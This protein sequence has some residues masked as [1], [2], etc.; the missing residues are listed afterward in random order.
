MVRERLSTPIGRPAGRPRVPGMPHARPA[1]VLVA[2]CARGRRG[3]EPI[4]LMI[5][6][7]A[8][9]RMHAGEISFPGGKPDPSDAD[10]LDTALRE[11]R[12]EVNLDVGRGQVV[13]QLDAVGTAGTGFAILPF[14][15]VVAGGGPE[16]GAGARGGLRAAAGEVDEIIEFPLGPLLATMSADDDPMHR[17]AHEMLAF[18]LGGRTVWGASA[19]ILGQVARR[20]GVAPPGLGAPPVQ[21]APG[22]GG[23]PCPRPGAGRAGQTL[24]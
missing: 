24:V 5:R 7:R 6:K 22:A 3:G 12:E 21:R 14:A 1:A 8:G 18:S 10:L 11:T 9:L 16:G 15:A 4:V 19:R 20:L 13:G 17:S 23:P 2:V